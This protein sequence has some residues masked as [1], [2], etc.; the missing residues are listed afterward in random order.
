[1]RRREQVVLRRDNGCIPAATGGCFR[2]RAEARV[3]AELG[4]GESRNAPLKQ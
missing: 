4:P 2:E 3:R 1:M